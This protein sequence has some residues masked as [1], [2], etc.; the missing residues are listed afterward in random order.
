MTMAIKSIRPA[1]WLLSVANILLPVAILTFAAG[2]FPYKP[3]IPGVNHG[4]DF[5]LGIK[6]E[7]AF[8]KVIFIV[9]DALRR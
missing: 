3:F 5:G 6:V 2:F 8:D 7:P 9:V 4:V 1:L